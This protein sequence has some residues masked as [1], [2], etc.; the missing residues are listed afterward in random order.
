MRHL[1]C[2]SQQIGFHC[3]ICTEFLL[4]GLSQAQRRVQAQHVD[5]IQAFCRVG[6]A[7]YCTRICKKYLWDIGP[8][9]RALSRCIFFISCVAWKKHQGLKP[10][11]V[12]RWS[13]G[14]EEGDPLFVP[15][16]MGNARVRA[17]HQA[18]RYSVAASQRD[19]VPKCLGKK[20]TNKYRRY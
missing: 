8:A 5:L 15:P 19:Q 17:Q 14:G 6:N 3:A 20:N 13:A 9:R 4:L 18:G 1:V 11:C 2:T 10:A 16:Q 7:V 12:C